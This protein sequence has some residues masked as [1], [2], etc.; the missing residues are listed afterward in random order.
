VLDDERPAGGRVA[1][2]AADPLRPFA[3]AVA[4]VFVRFVISVP[5]L[6]VRVSVRAATR[7]DVGAPDGAL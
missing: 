2:R 3:F 4:V 1:G 5:P 6:S 7:A